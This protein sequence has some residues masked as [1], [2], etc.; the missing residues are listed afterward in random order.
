MLEISWKD[1]TL[2]CFSILVSVFY[3][4]QGGNNDGQLANR[5]IYVAVFFVFSQDLYWLFEFRWVK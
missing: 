1:F 2:I 3:G 5:R 4:I